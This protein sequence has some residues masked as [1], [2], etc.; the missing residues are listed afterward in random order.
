MG[1][2]RD[3]IDRLAQSD[4]RFAVLT[5]PTFDRWTAGRSRR[6]MAVTDVLLSLVLAVLLAG[7]SALLPR[8]LHEG[9][10]LLTGI[11]TLAT[12]R[13]AEL[14][15]QSRTRGGTQ[16]YRLVVTYEFTGTDAR[17]HQGSSYRNDISAPVRIE[18]GQPIAIFYDPANPEVSTI[19]HNLRTDVVALAL[20]LPFIALVPGGLIAIY[21]YRTLRWRRSAGRAT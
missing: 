8:L 6:A 4:E 10:L 3:R 11:E 20:F 14:T 2:I 17:R 13:A 16:L 21:L 12:V 15:E 7:V 1:W 19:D 18:A 5:Q 9:R